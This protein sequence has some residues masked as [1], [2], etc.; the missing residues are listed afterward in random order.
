VSEHKEISR[1]ILKLAEKIPSGFECKPSCG[2]CC[3]ERITVH[4]A[5]WEE[6][7]KPLAEELF[8]NR[9][10]MLIY[11]STPSEQNLL[12]MFD[13]QRGCCPFLG[14]DM[15]TCSIYD[16]RPFV[17]RQYGQHWGMWCGEGVAC[18]P[19]AEIQEEVVLEFAMLMLAGTPDVD[20]KLLSA[21]K[22]ADKRRRLEAWREKYGK[23]GDQVPMD[24]D[25]LSQFHSLP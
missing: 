20:R 7:L 14:D 11:S 4:K 6:V 2:E 12:Q 9:E 16:S 19:E 5:E 24:L 21:D 18:P 23:K 3:K 10:V 8:D 17:C 22:R 25:E 1:K 15:V 13:P